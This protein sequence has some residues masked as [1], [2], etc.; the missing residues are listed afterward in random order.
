MSQVAIP[1]CFFPGTTYFVDDSRDFLVNFTLQLD[2]NLAYK[3]FSSPFDALDSLET[4]RHVFQGLNERCMSEYLESTAWPLTSQTVNVDLGAIHSEVNNP[5]RFSEVTV[6][7]VDYAMPGM[8]GLDFF[9]KIKDLPVKKIMLT[10]QADE[11][12]AVQAFNE[13]VID[14]FIRKNQADVAEQ[15][16][17]SIADLHL[18]YFKEMS[19]MIIKMLS[20]NASHFLLDPK[21]SNFIAE[22]CKKNNI[23]EYYL[24]ENSGSFLMLDADG[25]SYS[26]IVKSEQDLKLYYELACDNHA[27]EDTLEAL[28]TG[29]KIPYFCNNV[30]EWNEWSTSLHPAEKVACEQTYYFGLVKDTAPFDIQKEGLRSYNQFLDEL[31][32]DTGR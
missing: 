22:M 15:I 26:L 30:E 19:E 29:Q 23:I 1:I 2:D 7:V 14:K 3:L 27:P 17:Q 20:L 12:I 9:R 16:T 8:N 25:N 11:Q 18:Q 5:N 24:T 28:R 13:N 4:S 10:G 32:K 31:H 6:I 21:F